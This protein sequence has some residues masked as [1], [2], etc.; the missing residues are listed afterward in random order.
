MKKHMIVSCVP[1]KFD[2]NWGDKCF[3][4]TIW[5]LNQFRYKLTLLHPSRH[6]IPKIHSI[7]P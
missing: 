3:D 5:H 2:Y 4:N 6:R 1:Q 7:H